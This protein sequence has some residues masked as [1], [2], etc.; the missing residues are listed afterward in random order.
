MEV[1]RINNV[2]EITKPFEWA[3]GGGSTQLYY[4]GNKGINSSRILS[5]GVFIKEL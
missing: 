5:H 3:M 2:N 1:K 4:K